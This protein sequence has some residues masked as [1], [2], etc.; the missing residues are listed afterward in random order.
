MANGVEDNS[1]FSIRGTVFED[2]RLH[3]EGKP[4]KQ[5]FNKNQMKLPFR[6]FWE[7][8][9]TKIRQLHLQREKDNIF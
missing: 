1:N 2:Y 4:Q 8:V 3:S 7:K 6:D 5:D 9:D